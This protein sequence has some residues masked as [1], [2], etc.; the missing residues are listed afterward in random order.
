MAYAQNVPPDRELQARIFLTGLLLVITGVI[1]ALLLARAGAGIGLIVVIELLLLFL[2]YWF[3]DQIALHAM[4]A[5]V[6]GRLEAPELHAMVD[7]L[8]EEAEMPTPRVAIA[9]TDMPNAFA[10][11]RS[12]KAAVVCVTTG[13]QYRLNDDELEAVLSHE[14]AH[15]AHRDVAIMTIASGVGM[16][17][18]LL[19][20]VTLWNGMGSRD[21]KRDAL[22]V[23]AVMFISIA[24][25]TI[26]FLLIRML[27]R[28]REFAADRAG[29]FLTKHPEHLASALI[30]ISGEL[31]KIPQRDLR[32]SEAFDAF[33]IAPALGIKGGMSMASL[34]STHPPLEK[35]L[36]ALRQIE[37]EMTTA[38]STASLPS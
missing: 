9:D 4:G 29:A 23:A 16:L 12:S 38:S 6:V 8:C 28:Y 17:A 34:F 36:A 5:K 14:I 15:V 26:S 31:S 10:A 37:I 2:Q 33:F 18:G 3:S 32:T 22:P 30:K 27:S 19:T 21:K 13:L 1:V 24:M 11:G 20:Q 35:R 7:R 25:Y